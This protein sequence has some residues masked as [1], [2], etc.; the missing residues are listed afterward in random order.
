MKILLIA[1][2]PFFQQRGTPIAVKLIAETLCEFGHEVD[3]LTYHEG[4]DIEVK[5][6]NLYRIS[7]PLF[8]NNIPIGF[9]FKKVISDIYLSFSLIKLVIKNK[10]DVIH[11]VEESIFPAV[12]LNRLAKK[13]LIYDMDSSLVDQLLEKWQ[14]L[15]RYQKIFD[16]FEGWAVKRSEIVI[17]VCQSLAN[18]VRQYDSNKKIFVL[19]DIGFENSSDNQE[20]LR[21]TL[22]L[23]GVIVLYVGNLEHYQ[24]IDLFLES[25]VK[26]NSQIPYSVVIIGGKKDDI[27]KYTEKAKTL[28]ISDKIYFIGPRL[29]KDL[30]VYL[31]QADVLLSPRLKGKNTPMKLYSYLISGKPVLATNIESHTQIIDNSCSRLVEPDPESFAK[32]FQELIEN[33]DLRKKIGEAGKTLAKKNYSLESYKLKL[34]NIYDQLNR[35]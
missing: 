12:L 23:K 16:V 18:K 15:T 22:N 21:Q 30:P 28:G 31:A 32:G 20:D 4:S 25:V 24:G 14:S 9:S 7:K 5:G 1:P 19:E 26:I 6:L 17:P 10:Y 13:K 27:N 8:A 29:L 33:E 34:K 3:L 2:H 11:A 35:V